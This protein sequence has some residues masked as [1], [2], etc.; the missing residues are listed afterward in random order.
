MP[1]E[2]IITTD[3]SETVP[4]DQ[5]V[6]PIPV[7]H[8]RVAM[9]SLRADGS[10]DQTNPVIIGDP[11]FAVAAAKRQFTEQAVAA[12]D[13]ANRPVPAG[14]VTVIGNADGPDEVVPAT[15]GEETA[16]QA[17]HVEVAKTAQAAAEAV[18]TELAV[19]VTPPDS[20]QVTGEPVSDEE[21]ADLP[22][23]EVEAA[24]GSDVTAVP[25]ADGMA[26]LVHGDH[27][28]ADSGEHSV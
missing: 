26:V 13:A 6:N 5:P 23:A 1:D 8:D 25:G 21:A 11:A 15:R 12:V 20:E 3:T 16:L 10:P 28:S 22:P 17:A 2:I 19:A 27:Q 4:A 24:P 14:D 18:V 9:L 7:P